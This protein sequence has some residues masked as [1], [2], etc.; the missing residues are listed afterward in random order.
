MASR[1]KKRSGNPQGN[2]GARTPI[3]CYGVTS[4]T[5]TADG[6]EVKCRKIEVAPT[7]V[8]AKAA[9]EPPLIEERQV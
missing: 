7:G 5:P 1:Q 6:F 8:A 9:D 2:P 4:I 3:V